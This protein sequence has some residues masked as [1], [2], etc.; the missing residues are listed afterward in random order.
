MV[1]VASAP[2]SRARTYSSVDRCGPDLKAG[3]GAR[4]VGEAAPER[5]RWRQ[6]ARHPDLP[7]NR[8]RATWEPATLASVEP[9]PRRS[10]V[11]QRQK[12][13]GDRRSEEHTSEL[14][15]PVHLVC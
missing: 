8:T 4:S 9:G 2:T 5:E 6:R 3:G 1:L 13:E 15:S 11:Q 10:Q 14:Q 7:A 12:V